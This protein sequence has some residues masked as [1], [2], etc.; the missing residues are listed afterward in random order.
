MKRISLALFFLLLIPAVHSLKAS[1]RE[2]EIVEIGNK[3]LLASFGMIRGSI[4]FKLGEYVWPP[5]EIWLVPEGTLP[6]YYKSTG[7]Y[8][9]IPENITFSTC[10]TSVY[11]NDTWGYAFK[12]LP[13]QI[14]E[15]G[16][17]CG[18]AYAGSYDVIAK[19]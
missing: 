2:G 19:F 3:E 7:T 16:S 13:S 14:Q 12:V 18:L 5:K 10:K 9:E 4:N 17:F 6:S 1:I 15:N 11:Y 8:L